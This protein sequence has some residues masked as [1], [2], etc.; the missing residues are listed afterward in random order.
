MNKILSK[1][2]SI[3]LMII[4]IQAFY[5]STIIATKDD[6][7]TSLNSDNIYEILG[8]DYYATQEEIKS[9]Y[10]REA[11]KCHPDKNLCNSNEATHQFQK[12]QHS[13]SILSN[14]EERAYYDQTLREATI[15]NFFRSFCIK[16]VY[17]SSKICT[18]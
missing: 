8:V 14:P 4:I 17:C 7:I 9:A 3:Y 2:R 1:N 13:Y 12:L 16:I 15:I 5:N 11:F 18:F 6:T 10:K